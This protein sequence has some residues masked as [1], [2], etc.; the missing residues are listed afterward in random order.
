MH[1]FPVTPRPHKLYTSSAT[2]KHMRW[3]SKRQR[4]GVLCHPFDGKAWKHFDMTYPDFAKE[5][6]NVRLG[7]CTDGFA[8][9]VS[10]DKLY[11]TWP[12]ILT[13]YN[14]PL[15]MCMKNQYMF[16]TVIVPG[17]KNPKNEIDVYLQPLVV[18]LSNMW[19]DGIVTYD[20]STE[21]NFRMHASL[22]WTISDF[23]AY[24]MF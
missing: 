5:S 11:S 1:Y 4:D 12:V 6:R 24:G 23:P 2:A 8:P 21:N 20:V 9:F 19:K 22:L 14:L 15:W 18:E 13:P 17:P 16:L 7:L 10:F 3:H